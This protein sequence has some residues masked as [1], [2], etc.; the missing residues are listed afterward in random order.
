MISVP[1][2]GNYTFL[3][4]LFANA[5]VVIDLETKIHRPENRSIDSQSG[6]GF[7]FG[8][9]GQYHF[10]KMTVLV[11]PFFQKHALVPFAINKYP[12]RLAELGVKLGLGYNF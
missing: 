11:N 4:Y 9:G 3:R 2:Y 8:I 10:K 5:G 6:I 12:E 7:G 1:F